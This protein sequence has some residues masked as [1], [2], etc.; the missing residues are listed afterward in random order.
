MNWAVT[1]FTAILFFVL[2]PGILLRLPSNGSK[3]TVAAVHAVVF[4]LVFHFTHKL[5]WS[6]T[7]SSHRDGFNGNIHS[8]GLNLPGQK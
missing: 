2:T 6:L 8:L 5:V 4:A 7:L 1:L 3:Y